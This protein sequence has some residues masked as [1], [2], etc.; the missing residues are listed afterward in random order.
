MLAA[1]ALVL[2]PLMWRR[3]HIGRVEGGVLLIAFV[4]F[5]ALTLVRGG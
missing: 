3:A 4:A 2:V 5:T 1:S